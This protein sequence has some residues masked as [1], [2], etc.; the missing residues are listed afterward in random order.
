MTNKTKG[1]VKLR[2]RLKVKRHRRKSMAFR[3]RMKRL[4]ADI[5]SNLISGLTTAAILKLLGW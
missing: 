4:P 3:E 2:V 1:V 5:L